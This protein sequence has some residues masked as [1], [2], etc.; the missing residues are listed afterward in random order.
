MPGRRCG[1]DSD[2]GWILGLGIVALLFIL[3][4]VGVAPFFVALPIMVLVV[5]LV[6]L[7][8]LL[9][10]RERPSGAES[11]VPSTQEASYEPVTD[12][13]ER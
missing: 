9:A 4:A 11:G 8:P 1:Q 13:S 5:A 3:T 6:L 7:P 12:P 2:M 10:A